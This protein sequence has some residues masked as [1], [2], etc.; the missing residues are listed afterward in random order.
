MMNLDLW[1]TK[2]IAGKLFDFARNN[3]ERI[4]YPDQDAINVVCKNDKIILPPRYGVLVQFFRFK[5]FIKENLLEMRELMENPQ[6]IHF[7]GYQPWYY[8]KDKSMH[9][10]LWWKTF[11]SLRAFPKVYLT[12]AFYFF[13]YW[14]KRL[15]IFFGLI[16]PKSKYYML[17]WYYSHPRIKYDEV[18]KTVETLKSKP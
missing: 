12:Y 13:F 7:A 5:D 11:R 3:P 18:M 8:F 4:K 16:K 14:L 17:G 15:L 1:R 10:H 6:I 2:G 9:S